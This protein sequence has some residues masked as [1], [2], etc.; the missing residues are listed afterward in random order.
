MNWIPLKERLPEITGKLTP[1]IV[2]CFNCPRFAYH[3]EDG[4]YIFNGDFEYNKYTQAGRESVEHMSS[5][6][7]SHWMPMPNAPEE[8]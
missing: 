8:K 2:F 6:F 4:F 3:L 7:I 1:I 5:K